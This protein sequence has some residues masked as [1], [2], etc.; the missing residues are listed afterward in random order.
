MRKSIRTHA[1]GHAH[2]RVHARTCHSKHTRQHTQD[3]SG[4]T[5]D[6][7]IRVGDSASMRVFDTEKGRRE[8]TKRRKEHE[9]RKA[10]DEHLG[11][12]SSLPAAA[13]HSPSK[14]FK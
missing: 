9:E 2:T 7:N 3:E 12:A 11:T 10:R 5:G 8:L 14:F 13:L 6:R 1:Q 4:A